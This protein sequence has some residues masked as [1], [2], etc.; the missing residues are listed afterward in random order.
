MEVE[1]KVE[2]GVEVEEK[3]RRQKKPSVPR[4]GNPEKKMEYRSRVIQLRSSRPQGP[5]V[6]WHRK[7]K[8]LHILA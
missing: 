8:P 2:I 4:P 5:L 3:K 1:V 7:K 6:H